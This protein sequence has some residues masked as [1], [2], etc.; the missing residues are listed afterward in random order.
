M[1]ETQPFCVNCLR[2]DNRGPNGFKVKAC[3][4]RFL[5]ESVEC[6]STRRSM[7]RRCDRRA[8]AAQNAVSRRSLLKKLGV[9]LAILVLNAML[10]R[11]ESTA[12]ET[13]VRNRM[14]FVTRFEIGGDDQSSDCCAHSAM[15]TELSRI[16]LSCGFA[17]WRIKFFHIV[18]MVHQGRGCFPY[19]RFGVC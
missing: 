1:P 9:S 6:G 17:Q 4:Q 8:L 15:Y 10:V 3:I 12:H 7:W 5:I 11:A 13:I 16:G 19:S 2:S 18:S 14:V